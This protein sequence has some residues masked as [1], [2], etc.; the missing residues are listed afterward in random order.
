MQRV[1]VISNNPPHVAT[2]EAAILL[3]GREVRIAPSPERGLAAARE[4]RPQLILLDAGGGMTAGEL[5]AFLRDPQV[6]DG[7]AVIVIAEGELLQLVG[8]G[9]EV[10]DIVVPPLHGDELR[11]RVSRVLWR[12]TGVDDGLRLRRGGLL[13]DLARYQV[14]IEGEIVDLTYK[15]Y[16]LLC[17]LASNPGKPFTREALLNRVWGYDYYGGSRTVDVH[18]RRIRS[19]IDRHEQFIETVRNV[20]YRF[21]DFDPPRAAAEPPA[22]VPPP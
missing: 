6:A 22:A 4:W 7:V 15:E 2:A 9:V 21:A 1:L 14:S 13:I 3:D 8:P 12:R 5:A 20:G 16:E 18:I 10:D 19:K 17:F 11:T